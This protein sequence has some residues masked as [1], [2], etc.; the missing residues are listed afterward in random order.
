LIFVQMKI[1]VNC[2]KQFRNILNVLK[3]FR[4]KLKYAHMKWF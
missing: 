4:N 2:L 3:G 1:I